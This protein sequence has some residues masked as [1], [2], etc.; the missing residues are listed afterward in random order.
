MAEHEKEEPREVE[1]RVAVT[2]DVLNQVQ[3]ARSFPR[4]VSKAMTR[5]MEL[6]TRDI[7][8]A[9]SCFYTLK[10]KDKRTGEVKKIQGPAIRLAEM[11]GHCLGN[12]R[13]GGRAEGEEDRYVV[14]QG[15]AHELESNLFVSIEARRRITTRD[16]VRYGDD[17]V[18]TT[19][20]AGIAIAMRNAMF[21]A[22]PSFIWKPAYEA[23]IDKA[24]GDASTLADR[25]QKMIGKFALMGVGVE[26]V[27][28]FCEKPTLEEITL[29]DL[30]DLIGAFN[31]IREGEQTVDQ[32]FGAQAAPIEPPKS[33][34]ETAAEKPEGSQAATEAPPP[35]G[36]SLPGPG[37]AGPGQ[38]VGAPLA[39]E[40]SAP[41]KPNGTNGKSLRQTCWDLLC[42]TAKK[43][44]KGAPALLQE[45]T[46][47]SSLS[48]L[49]D[50]EVDVLTG[51]LK[52]L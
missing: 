50:Q 44:Q 5:L 38:P 13:W 27:L 3:I 40:A 6:A 37:P 29:E 21:K 31:S 39:A 34:A 42:K 33:Q 25:R 47:K 20:M 48:E 45:L 30:Q 1:T 19:T 2:A 15:V 41:K 18:T 4:N 51:K 22:I 14:C 24:V 9:E 32:V 43:Q 17:M 11:T 10:R 36:A 52:G 16:G 23:A 12:L 7:E 35:P 28:A 46:K 49:N 8:T 26:K